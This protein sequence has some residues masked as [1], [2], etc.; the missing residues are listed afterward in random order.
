M[1]L[2]IEWD[3]EK[4]A[5][6]ESRH[7]VSF[8]E[9]ATVLSDPLSI[10]LPDPDHSL[11]EERLLLLGQSASGRFLIIALTERGDAVR[12]I[13]ARPMTSRERRTYERAIER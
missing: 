4:A 2:R 10:T 1:S 3:P 9:A 8:S 7:G 12:L 13:S 6:N 11:D 5:A